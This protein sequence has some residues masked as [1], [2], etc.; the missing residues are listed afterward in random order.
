MGLPL[1]RPPPPSKA[2]FGPFAPCCNTT[3]GVFCSPPL[4]FGDLFSVVSIAPWGE[5]RAGV[6]TECSCIQCQE[7]R[8][9]LQRIFLSLLQNNSKCCYIAR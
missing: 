8:I 9:I 4:P 1:L 6:R 2:S 5:G 3:G 7:K